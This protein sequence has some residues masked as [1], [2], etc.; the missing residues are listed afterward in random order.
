MILLHLEVVVTRRGML[1]GLLAS[2][3]VLRGRVASG[4][5]KAERCPVILRHQHRLG[6][7]MHQKALAKAAA[8]MCGLRPRGKLRRMTERGRLLLR[9]WNDASLG[10][11]YS[12]VCG[13]LGL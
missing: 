13:V 8:S 7:Q 5:V 10:E 1:G 11:V 4:A 6:G 2:R 9:M 3:G 12:R